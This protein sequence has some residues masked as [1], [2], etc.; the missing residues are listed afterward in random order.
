M[1]RFAAVLA[2]MLFLGAGPIW[3]GP[4]RAG[5]L[6]AGL[7]AIRTSTSE[8]AGDVRRAPEEADDAAARDNLAQAVAPEAASAV[9]PEAAAARNH[10][11]KAALVDAEAAR[12]ALQQALT[13]ANEKRQALAARAE[14]STAEAASVREALAVA[15][16]EIEDL[17]MSALV[18]N[19]G[20]VAH[21]EALAAARQEI[22]QLKAS[23]AKAETGLR[24]ARASLTKAAVLAPAPEKTIEGSADV[25][26]LAELPAGGE[27]APVEDRL[28]AR[29]NAL[30][31]LGD[32]A[33]ARLFYE[34]ALDNG[35][36]RAATVIG[37][38]YDPV[39]L[40]RLK[41]VGAPAEPEKAEAWYR[42]AIAAGD[43]SVVERLKALTAS[44]AN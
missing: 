10:E 9:S 44:P 37:E 34:L 25:P 13:D 26:D 23:L 8:Q 7:E 28:M 6:A 12:R 41:V 18:A 36:P 31:A 24:A 22:A 19:A 40:K 15:R 5:S 39:Y 14:A 4:V 43:T 17:A 32:I 30:L 11:L 21:D 35:H 29:G 27:P 3:S 38:T 20:S 33:S 1:R 42:R 2:L 16:K